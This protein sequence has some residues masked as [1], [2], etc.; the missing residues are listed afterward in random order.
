M[1]V[2]ED[3]YPNYRDKE[4]GRRVTL[5]N[6]GRCRGNTNAG[7]YR[8]MQRVYN[9]N[10]SFLQRYLSMPDSLNASNLY[11]V[12][13]PGSTER[14]L[15]RSKKMAN[16]H[17]VC[18]KVKLAYERINESR[19][20]NAINYV[21]LGSIHGGPPLHQGLTLDEQGNLLLIKGKS[22]DL[23]KS[24][25][26]SAARD[27]KFYIAKIDLWE[28]YKIQF[29]RLSIN[30]EGQ[31][32]AWAKRE[33][34]QYEIE[35]NMEDITK[36]IY[37]DR[38]VDTTSHIVVQVTKLS[39]PVHNYSSL[40]FNLDEKNSIKFFFT[41]GAIY[42]KEIWNDKYRY[43]YDLMKHKLNLPLPSRAKI[44]SATKVANQVKL[45]IVQDGA[46]RIK[47]FSPHHVNMQTCNVKHLS[48]KPVQNFYSGTGA[49]PYEKV[50]SGLPFDRQRLGNFSSKNIPLLSS[51]IE[52]FRG[53]FKKAK[54]AHFAGDNYRTGRFLVKA[55]DPGVQCVVET[56]REAVS[57]KTPSSGLAQRQGIVQEISQLSGFVQDT[58]LDK[59][60]SSASDYFNKTTP[61]AQ[62]LKLSLSLLEENDSVSLKI[63][64]NAALFFG[65]AAAGIPF[66]GWFAGVL[67]RRG[68]EVSLTLTKSESGNIY[69]SF[70]KNNANSLVVLAGTGQ[71]LEDK[72]KLLSASGIDFITFLPVEANLI[73]AGN[74]ENE[75]SFNFE[76]KWCDIDFFL[77]K[78]LNPGDMIEQV[79][80]WVTGATLKKTRD[81][82]IT[83][84]LEAKSELRGQVGFMANANTFLVLPRTAMGAAATVN[85][86]DYAKSESVTISDFGDKNNLLKEKSSKTIFLSSSLNAYDEIKIMPIALTGLNAPGNQIMCYPLP[87]VEESNQ[88]LPF[89]HNKVSRFFHL[90]DKSLHQKFPPLGV[91]EG[92]IT[93]T[94][95]ESD[96]L[97]G[98]QINGPER[99]ELPLNLNGPYGGVQELIESLKLALKRASTDE[100]GYQSIKPG[101]SLGS[102][103]ISSGDFKENLLLA[104][105]NLRPQVSPFTP[106]AKPTFRTRINR[107]LKPWTKN[108]TLREYLTQQAGKNVSNDGPAADSA[109]T[110]FDFVKAIE[111]YAARSN[112]KSN[113]KRSAVMAVA[114]YRLQKHTRDVFGKEFDRICDSVNQ[115]SEAGRIIDSELRWLMDLKQLLLVDKSGKNPFYQLDNIAMVRQNAITL[116]V[117]TLPFTLFHIARKTTLVYSKSLSTINFE[118]RDGELFPYKFISS[119]K[120]M[121]DL[122]L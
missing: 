22:K 113:G 68:N 95:V 6:G 53:N 28:E 98:A 51:L 59:V 101:E 119:A 83:L 23:F 71:G 112:R 82:N 16:I 45:C 109:R 76:I 49:D 55:I 12:S 20:L 111:K 105:K 40:Q 17:C 117:S 38:P 4:Y 43:S 80:E 121:P 19:R 56:V 69:F 33:N 86:C 85:F 41:N 8:T 10:N 30:H 99:S 36:E 52:N 47:Y 107:A 29:S 81:K 31:L 9:S 106:D 1:K 32:I 67:A 54:N 58:R 78:L 97:T 104:A 115:K 14:P 91:V 102:F 87:L 94:T 63:S 42:L 3:I 21:Y 84:S 116:E 11:D 70:I 64:K 57:P 61:L 44:L 39:I 114:T 75:H 48:H 2:T 89:N 27:S 66:V 90:D 108:T 122:F 100:H 110:A 74:S 5:S 79:E 103:I 72:G 46:T 65:I 26:L 34:V 13:I 96:S 15:Q 24:G 93:D 25:W 77:E 88:Q 18:V 118:Y 120:I 60:F 73:L 50:R 37:L 92:N 62:N 7:I 35:F